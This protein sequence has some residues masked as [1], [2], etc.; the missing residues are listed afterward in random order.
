MIKER[1]LIGLAIIAV[2]AAC[3][4]GGGG[5]SSVP[6]STL[7]GGGGSV[8]ATPTPGVAVSPSSVPAGDAVASVSI[9]M[10]KGTYAASSR[11]T[12]AIGT[13]TQSIVFT[14]LQQNGT[15]I[16]GTPQVFGLTMSSTY[17]T[18]NATTLNLSCVLPV[19]APIGQDVFLAQTYDA[20]NGTGNLTGSGA[21]ALSVGQNTSNTA[22]IVLNAQVAAVYVY[23]GITYLGGIPEAI[24][25]HAGTEASRRPLVL[26]STAPTSTPIFI[27]AVD[28]S[29]NT[30]LN[31]SVYNAP[32]YLQL[33][34][35]P[36]GSYTA[37]VTL[38]ATYASG[39]QS[40]CT[41]GTATVS[42]WYASLPICSPS[43]TVTASLSPNGGADPSN[44][45]FVFGWT[46]PSYLVPTPAPAQSPQ[47]LPTFPST[48]SYAY[49]YV[50]YP[51][52]SPVPSNT[53]SLTVV[54]S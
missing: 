32:I 19:D 48:N 2:L 41:G 18:V 21:V 25:R 38:T 37:D 54:G 44:Y 26:P 50:T 11:R 34:F 31:P 35:S 7:P 1:S 30:I 10:A 47:P 28:S 49:L 4:G 14:L 24:A 3:G 17:C 29:G 40:P 33:A 51:T 16:T 5:G 27:V 46:S 39:D 8:A 53:G 9:T 6:S 45:A 20:A 43:D 22:S 36:Y 12:Q 23:A 13:G 52:P 42:S 15:T